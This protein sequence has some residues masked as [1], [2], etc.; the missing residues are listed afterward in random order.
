MLFK[1]RNCLRVFVIEDT[2]D[3]LRQAM[4]RIAIRIRHRD[5]GEDHTSVGIK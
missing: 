3:R 1:G 4:N 5:I 2:K